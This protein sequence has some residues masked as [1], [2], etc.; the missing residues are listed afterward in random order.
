MKIKKVKKGSTYILVIFMASSILI[1]GTATLALISSDYK[2]RINQSKEVKNIYESEAGLDLVYNLI[3]KNCDTAVIYANNVV[4]KEFKDKSDASYDKLNKQFKE[5]FMGFLGQAYAGETMDFQ[6]DCSLQYALTNKMYMKAKSFPVGADMNE[7]RADKQNYEISNEEMKLEG[8][9]DIV[10]TD[11]EV[12]ADNKRII[13]SVEST[14]K[15]EVKQN[16]NLDNK[17]TI[18]T[19]YTIKAPDYADNVNLEDVSK[20]VNDYQVEKGLFVDGDVNIENTDLTI[21]GTAWVKGQDTVLSNDSYYAYAKY[22]SGILINNGMLDA[23]GN[24]STNNTVSLKNNAYMNISSGSDGTG[25]SLYANNVYLG[26]GRRLEVAEKENY[27]DNHVNI[28]NNIIANNDLTMDAK[29]S[30]VLAGNYY[31]ISDKTEKVNGSKQNAAYNSSSII[32]N[33]DDNSEVNITNDAYVNGLAYIDFNGDKSY[34]KTGESVAVI[35]NYL[36]YTKRLLSD[37]GVKFNRHIISDNNGEVDSME[38]VELIDENADDY[39]LKVSHFVDY[40]KDSDNA[41]KDGGISVGGKLYSIGASVNKNLEGK[42]LTSSVEDIEAMTNETYKKKDE[43]GTNVYSLGY[44]EGELNGKKRYDSVVD[45]SKDS[46]KSLSSQI[47]FS[48]LPTN[49]EFTE[50]KSKIDVKYGHSILD[51]DDRE[52]G[53]SALVIEDGILKQS[54]GDQIGDLRSIDPA[55]AG[56]VKAV[57]ITKGDLIIKGNTD[58]VGC[59]IVG[60]NLYIENSKETTNPK[61]SITYHKDVIENIIAFNYEKYDGLFKNDAYQVGTNNITIGQKSEIEKNDKSDWY[62]KGWYDANTYLKQGLWKLKENQTSAMHTAK[63][64]GGEVDA[65]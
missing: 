62:D 31:G 12:D 49:N 23:N 25:G 43:Y 24:V 17:K 59:V 8:I 30:S 4:Y 16:G 47:D 58:I 28:K 55:Y 45:G 40:Y 2:N 27:K 44:Y 36:A 15:S 46:I 5:S 26:A 32:I 54:N 1:T 3:V 14:F 33:T 41:I 19:K 6:K 20:Q 56:K 10:I 11:Y 65:D 64:V 38:L 21:N 7:Y 37:S 53:S 57:I 51:G 52:K 34:Y 39:N 42:A 29:D 63:T 48:K 13:I 9:S 50:L 60:G 18:S 22:S 35:G 61:V